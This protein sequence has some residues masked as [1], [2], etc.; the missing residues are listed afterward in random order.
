MKKSFLLLTTAILLSTSFV[1]A[2]DRDNEDG[3]SSVATRLP[4]YVD[5]KGMPPINAKP[6]NAAKLFPLP[7]SNPNQEVYI[8]GE[9]MPP[10]NTKPLN[11]SRL[12]PLPEAQRSEQK[13]SD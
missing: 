1:Q 5:G 8:D 2:G 6:L 12:F 13:K 3:S 7:P 4:V 9:G 10:I 11:A